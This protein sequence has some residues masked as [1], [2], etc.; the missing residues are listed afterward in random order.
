M[1]IFNPG[2]YFLEVR[3]ELG[4]EN[5]NPARYPIRLIPDKYP[6]AEI[7]NPDEDLEVAGNETIPVVYSARD[8]SGSPP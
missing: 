6:E 7:L 2:T 5:P 3:D 8:D 1:L 4:F